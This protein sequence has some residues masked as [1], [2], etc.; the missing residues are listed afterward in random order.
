[1]SIFRSMVTFVVC[2]R[3]TLT[4]RTDSGQYLRTAKN[5]K[6]AA[7]I[8]RNDDMPSIVFKVDQER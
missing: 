1:M 5:A 6:K 8:V 2:L 4:T 3:W 7:D